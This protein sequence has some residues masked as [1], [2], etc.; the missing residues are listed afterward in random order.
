MKKSS[1][2]WSIPWPMYQASCATAP[3]HPAA[4]KI[5]SA[6]D[7]GILGYYMY[8]NGQEFVDGDG[9]VKKGVESTIANVA[10]LG[11]DGMRDTDR[12]IL[13]IMIG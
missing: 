9:I 13:D 3:R 8:R 10:R 6:V 1:I 5:A 4:A 2:Q 11:R 12:E 7:A